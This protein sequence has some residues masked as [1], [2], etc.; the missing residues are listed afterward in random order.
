MSKMRRLT[1]SEKN[2]IRKS[3][4]SVKVVAGLLGCTIRTIGYHKKRGIWS[5]KK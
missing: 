4:L 3:T 1:E 5:D 2:F